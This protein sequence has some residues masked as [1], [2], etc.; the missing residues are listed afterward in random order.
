VHLVGRELRLIVAL[1]VLGLVEH[2]VAD[3]DWLL[4]RDEVLLEQE[5]LVVTFVLLK[6]VV[7]VNLV[8]CLL[9]ALV[10]RVRLALFFGID[11]LPTCLNICFWVS[12]GLE[13]SLLVD[14]S[15]I[16]NVGI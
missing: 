4:L 10:H 3:D 14:E 12:E 5:L 9:C 13:S 11:F 16:T 1:V 8:S 2:L 15:C 7:Q 6:N